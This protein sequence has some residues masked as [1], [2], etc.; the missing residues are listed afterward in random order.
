MTSLTDSLL[1]KLKL[2]AHDADAEL[3]AVAKREAA[4]KVADADVKKLEQALHLSGKSVEHYQESVA[5]LQRIKQLEGEAA[6][7]PAAS[8]AYV[9]ARDAVVA[10]QVETR[11]LEKE[12]REGLLQIQNACNAKY[13][14]HLM[15]V[16]V[17][18]ELERLQYSYPELF[19]GKAVDLDTVTLTSSNGANIIN[20]RDEN[21]PYREVPTGVWQAESTR[22][23]QIRGAAT[24]KLRKEYQD[25]RDAW[26]HKQPKDYNGHYVADE[27]FPKFEMPTWGEILAKGWN[28]TLDGMLA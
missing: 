9:M 8:G 25:K 3:I 28:K 6:K 23:Q 26:I 10:Y 11:R 17:H 13:S 2:K 15:A 22:R 12:R 16:K 18:S 4:N 27:P 1:G 14:K 20:C 7:L 24:V 21:A 5:L 19:D